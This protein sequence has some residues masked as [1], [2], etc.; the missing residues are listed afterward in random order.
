MVLEI[1]TLIQNRSLVFK[2]FSFQ[3]TLLGGNYVVKRMFFDTCL[4]IL[5][6]FAFFFIRGCRYPRVNTKMKININV[7]NN[8]WIF[9]GTT[10]ILIV[11]IIYVLV[12]FVFSL[13]NCSMRICFTSFHDGVGIVPD[14]KTK[15][16][17]V[18]VWN[19]LDLE[20]F[21]TMILNN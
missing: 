6:P 2:A 8:S 9:S 14:L 1:L 15:S 12:R 3:G 13:N 11:M 10:L 21:K 7:K 17:S 18:N 16:F 5:N 19:G 4:N 20:W